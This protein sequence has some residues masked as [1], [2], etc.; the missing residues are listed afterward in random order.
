MAFL[1]TKE[2]ID[3]TT[4]KRMENFS[5]DTDVAF[6]QFCKEIESQMGNVTYAVIDNGVYHVQKV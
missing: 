6:R 5:L 3:L 4:K 1:I 2:N